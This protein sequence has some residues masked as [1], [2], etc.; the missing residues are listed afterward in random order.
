MC[1]ITL[2]VQAHEFWIEPEAY[3]VDP[4]NPVTAMFRNGENFAG[5]ALSFIPNRSERFDIVSGDTVTEVP[6]RVGDNPAVN[7]AD[8]PEGLLT[9]LHETTDSTLTYREKEGR[10]GWER[11]VGFAEH[12]DLG[13][14][15]AAHVDRDLPQD[16]PTESY[17]RFAKALIA[18]GDGAGSDARRGLR[19]EFVAL[20]NPYVDDVSGGLPVQLF[21]DDAP[22]PD[23]QIEMFDKAPDGTVTVTLH[24]TD[25]EGRATLQVTP[26]HAYLIDSVTLLPLEPQAEGD[27]IWQTLWAALTLAIPQE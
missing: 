16:M 12:K 13:D 22:K 23:A 9:I 15:A 25:G 4:G 3:T 7:V 26:G 8:L 27:P 11:F 17:R 10:S 1:I 20:A 14:V 19:T 5:S 18:V 24:R 21:L 6:A 2:P